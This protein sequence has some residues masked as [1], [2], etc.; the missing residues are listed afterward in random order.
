MVFGPQQSSWK[1]VAAGT[2][3]IALGAIGCFSDRGVVIEVDIGDTEATSVELFIGKGACADDQPAGVSCATIVPQGATSPLA[4]QGDDKVWFRDHA[5][6]Y[7][8]D[9]NRNTHTATFHLKTD[10]ATTLPVVI[11]VAFAPSRES[12]CPIGTATLRGLPI[13]SNSALIVTTRLACANPVLPR[14]TDPQN[15]TGD[16]VMVWAKETSPS[17]C[18]VVEHWKSEQPVRRDFVVPADDPDCD[19]LLNA[20]ECN[21]NVYDGSSEAGQASN[22][23][24]FGFD[25]SNTCLL[26]SHKCTDVGGSM[27]STCVPQSPEHDQDP[28][29]VPWEFCN[30][31]MNTSLDP[32]CPQGLIA[33]PSSPIPRFECR[34]PISSE[35]ALCSGDNSTPI[36][37]DLFYS[38]DAKCDRQPLLGAFQFT[39]LSTNSASHTFG[40]VVM[41]LGSPNGNCNFPIT[42]TRSM[43]TSSSPSIDHGVIQLQTG[44][45]ITL[46]PI[47]F[48]FESC[49]TLAQFRCLPAGNMLPTDPLWTCAHTP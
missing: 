2:V 43:R 26:G 37:L 23:D 25:S 32:R 14:P 4:P 8:A 10:E 44:S 20:K 33:D 45:R 48:H 42:L 12:M 19:G 18:V 47:I 7:V 34:I 5:A 29:C 40:G 46:L 24:C 27:D 38:L 22:P 6:P 17:S 21:A 49:S 41:E 39:D 11:A 15:T 35:G 1:L 9:V 28:V 30:S 31:C 16:R 13:Q 3:M 36:S